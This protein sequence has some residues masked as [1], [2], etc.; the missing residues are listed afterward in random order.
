MVKLR[1]FKLFV[2]VGFPLLG[3]LYA[4]QFTGAF[5]K[6]KR[7]YVTPFKPFKAPEET[8][9]PG[10]AGESCSQEKS[11]SLAKSQQ[12]KVRLIN[13]WASWCAPCVEEFPAMI[14]LQSVLASS[15]F[16]IIFVSVDKE[17]KNVEEFYTKHQIRLEDS[18]S[19]WDKDQ[20]IAAKWGSAIL[21][22][23][24]VVRPDGWVVEKIIGAQQWTRPAVVKY[25]KDLADKFVTSVD[26]GSLFKDILGAGVTRAY[27]QKTESLVVAPI[28]HEQDK[29]TLEKLRKNI[30]IASD[31]LQKAEAAL[32]EEGRN[33]NEQKI[34]RDRKARE[35]NESSEE[36]D[37][38][39]KKNSEIETNLKKTQDSLVSEKNE[40]VRVENQIKNIQEKIKDLEQRLASAKDELVQTNKTLNTRLSSVETY[41]KAV[42]SLNE[43]LGSVK[44]KVEKARSVVQDKR[45]SLLEVEKDVAS[46]D[47]KYNEISRQVETSKGELNQQKK[48]LAEFEQ[49]LK[50]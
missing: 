7:E 32:K 3:W 45:A 4:Y 5:D 23:S 22:E 33:L 1:L 6:D 30:E 34:V 37:K 11:I 47:R 24:Y 10:S 40:K 16:E 31:N 36:L 14:E 35:L 25:F 19:L 48:K 9:C 8:L 41:E 15:P 17:W 20:A 27:A 28:I 46:R 50:K 42:E 13:F 38:V 18:R 29:K 26:T 49:V 43:E 21:P 44:S 12:P 2:I 39:Q